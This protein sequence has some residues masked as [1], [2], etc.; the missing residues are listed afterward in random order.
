MGFVLSD[1]SDGAVGAVGF[2]FYLVCLLL[3]VCAVRAFGQPK[4]GKTIACCLCA[5]LPS[6]LLS[7][8][9]SIYCARAYLNI[10]VMPP[11]TAYALTLP[12]WSLLLL[13]ALS[14]A[15]AAVLLVHLE[16]NVRRRL[17]AQS[18]CEGLDQLPDGICVSLP[19]GF[20]RLVNH[21]M[22]QISNAAF[23][24]GVVDTLHLD[25]RLEAQELM[26]GCSLQA[27]DGNLFLLLPD[28]SVWQMKQQTIRVNDRDMTEMIAYDVTE[29]YH[30]L[31]E[32]RQRNE[33]LAEV[34]RRLRD[35][36][37]NIDHIVREKEILSAKI[38]L[39]SNLGQS[40]LAV[41]SF[42][43]AE[44]SAREPVLR[45]LR[46][47]VA[48]LRNDSTAA[49]THV[50]DRMDALREAADAFDVALQIEGEIPPEH[51]KLLEIAIHECLMN[52]VKHAAGHRLDVRL[53]QA[54]K[55]VTVT[56]TNDGT[57]PD[58]PVLEAGGLANLRKLVEKQ[59][60]S[61]QIESAPVFR[62]VLRLNKQED[63]L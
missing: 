11:F 47:T 54:G 33:R 25:R 18:V 16:K 42:L 46:Q 59:G 20:P 27:Q 26:P 7:G 9:I 48:L 41:E 22:Q 24:T 39:H 60:G 4:T 23:G 45:Q 44:D 57:L 37:D 5:A 50:R 62:A 12:M 61:M 51:K 49:D 28:N 43:A 13:Q 8:A 30:D 29:R 10:S 34:N 56:L 14:F 38:R 53:E 32:L 58:G 31:A 6:F 15:A 19:D 63:D 2:G 21:R 1:L 40:L 35:Y 3:L 17:S 55:T 36:L 52:T